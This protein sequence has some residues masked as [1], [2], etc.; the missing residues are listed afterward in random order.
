MK[1]KP[2]R[3]HLKSKRINY[4]HED[5][6]GMQWRFVGGR[7]VSKLADKTLKDCGLPPIT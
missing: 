7:P 6:S 4:T 2:K 5:V 1:L 3:K